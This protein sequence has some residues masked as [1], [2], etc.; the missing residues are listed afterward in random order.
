[1]IVEGVRWIYLQKC[2]TNETWN[3][4]ISI[5]ERWSLCSAK[6]FILLQLYSG[7]FSSVCLT[8]TY[9]PTYLQWLCKLKC[10]TIVKPT[11]LLAWTWTIPAISN[12]FG[13]CLFTLWIYQR[14]KNWEWKKVSSVFTIYVC[15]CVCVFV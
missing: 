4:N 1:M 11:F 8:S 12:S 3:R 2:I 13:N 7:N 6:S 15:V 14:K 10:L 9:F 5:H